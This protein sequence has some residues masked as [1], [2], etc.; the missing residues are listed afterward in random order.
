MQI[1]GAL[2]TGQKISIVGDNVNWFI[3]VHDERLGHTSHMCH[4]FASA[5]IIDNAATTDIVSSSASCLEQDKNAIENLPHGT[6]ILPQVSSVTSQQCS[7]LHVIDILPS[8]NDFALVEARYVVLMSNIVTAIVPYFSDITDNISACTNRPAKFTDHF[9]IG[10]TESC[11]QHSI[12]V[13]PIQMKN[14]QNYQDVVDIL[15]AY[16]DELHTIAKKANIDISELRVQLSG[17]QL[18]RERF[19][20][21]KCLRAHH[22]LPK[23][24]YVHLT[25]ITF[26]LFHMEMNFLQLVFDRLFAASSVAEQGTLR[27]LKEILNYKQ[28]KD[29]IKNSFD[30]DL[31]FLQTVCQAYVVLAVMD[32][33]GMD[34]MTDIPN[35]H[36]FDGHQSRQLWFRN[37]MKDIV[38]KYI[39]ET[40]GTVIGM[41]CHII[42]DCIF[43]CSNHFVLIINCIISCF[44]N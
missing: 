41:L 18:T 28:V 22:L 25:P 17:D 8:D 40:D 43:N 35:K 32:Y 42:T 39:V 24:C 2:N 27:H 20:G 29:D 44:T 16:E 31:H 36:S 33:F 19:S 7:D 5:V 30:A 37:C 9:D 26:G 12:S 23:D 38:R 6:S 11:V 34:S 13:L 3:N 1:L 10:H 14:E 21:A 4:A 15:D